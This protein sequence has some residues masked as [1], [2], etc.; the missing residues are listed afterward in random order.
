MIVRSV[1]SSLRF[2]GSTI[3]A[4]YGKTMTIRE[5]FRHGTLLPLESDRTVAPS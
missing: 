2:Y 5:L 3:L 4:A 1:S